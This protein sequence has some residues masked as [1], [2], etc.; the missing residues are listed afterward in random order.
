MI[1]E[2][3]VERKQPAEFEPPTTEEGLR[4]RAVQRLR[5]Q[6]D[7]RTHVV[8]YLTTNA[9]LVAIWWVTGAAFFWPVF[10]I[11][12]W[13]IGVVAH[14]WDAYGPNWVTEARIQQEM[15]RMRR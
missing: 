7:F 8:V 14:A 15:D 11:A 10:P 13:G 9:L 5:K 2:E 12:I 3:Q 6:A 1:P 4:R